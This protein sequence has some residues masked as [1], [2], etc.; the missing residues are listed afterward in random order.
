M[1]AEGGVMMHGEW[2]LEQGKGYVCIVVDVGLKKGK[3]I[4][5]GFFEKGFLGLIWLG[6]P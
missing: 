3:I 1:A 2:W 6:V 5:C 4:R